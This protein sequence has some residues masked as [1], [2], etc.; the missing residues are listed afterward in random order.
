MH[1]N[2]NDVFEK[3]K[4]KKR[5]DNHH[6]PVVGDGGNKV[7]VQDAREG[8]GHPASRAFYPKEVLK[9]T[10]SRAMFYEP[11]RNYG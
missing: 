11:G 9:D 4:T 6:H 2:R 5:K 1:E 3:D 8:P 7:A 10:D